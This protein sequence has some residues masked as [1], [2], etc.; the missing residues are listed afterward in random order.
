MS[1]SAAQKLLQK[2]YYNPQNL[3]Y[4][5]SVKSLVEAA[6]KESPSVQR[7]DVLA[8]FKKQRVNQLWRPRPS[9]RFARNPFVIRGP[10]INFQLDIAYF[11]QFAGSNGGRK[12]ALVAV[13]AF[14]RK[15]YAFPQR[16][17]TAAETL[18]NFKR[19]V[20]ACPSIQSILTDLGKEFKSKDFYAF[21]RSKQIAFWASGNYDIKASIA[22]RFIRTLRSRIL[23]HFTAKKTQNWTKILPSLLRNYNHAHHRSIGMAPAE[24][25]ARNSTAIRRALYPKLTRA[26]QRYNR[27][28]RAQFPIGQR[29]R[30][31]RMPLTVF[32]KN[33]WNYTDEIYRVKKL[34]SR[35]VLQIEITEENGEPVTGRFYP[36]ELQP[37]K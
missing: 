11:D 14:S 32:E 31:L 10:G 23:R 25:T 1:E 18:T 7:K 19:L 15:A 8:F 3:A 17:K 26:Q 9:K 34:I 33:R 22:E 36:A 35:R 13:D 2:I 24:V 30:L 29:V 5:G 6:K 20:R 27:K 37:V 12:Y 16:T 28:M 4:L 21:L